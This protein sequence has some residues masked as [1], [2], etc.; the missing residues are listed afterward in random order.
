MISDVGAKSPLSNRTAG[1]TTLRRAGAGQLAGA[2]PTCSGPVGFPQRPG[3]PN[4]RHRHNHDV[5]VWSH[6]PGEWEWGTDHGHATNLFVLGGPVRGGKVYGQWPG[7]QPE[8][9]FEGRDLALTT[10]FRGV[11]G[12]LILKHLGN[13]NLDAVFPNYSV[14]SEQFRNLLT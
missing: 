11:F 3:E 10:D 7:L 14:K 6:C 1:T 12:E 4:G 8:Q 13:P 5:G 2:C 9:L